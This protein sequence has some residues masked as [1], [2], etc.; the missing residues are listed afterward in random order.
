MVKSR[1]MRWAEKMLWSVL[2]GT[3]LGLG[4]SGC[5]RSCDPPVEEESGVDDVYGPPAVERPEPEPAAKVKKVV[6]EQESEL[7]D[8]YGPP[9]APAE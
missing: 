8:V 2:C 1:S 5:V 4:A 7:D 3:M 9:T 6:E